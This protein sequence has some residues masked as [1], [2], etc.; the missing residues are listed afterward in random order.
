MTYKGPWIRGI[1]PETYDADKDSRGDLGHA[2]ADAL[3]GSG[4]LANHQ[5]LFPY[6]I[7][8]V[9]PIALKPFG[10][11]PLRRDLLARLDALKQ[12]GYSVQDVTARS[13]SDVVHYLVQVQKEIREQA[14]V[15]CPDILGKIARNSSTTP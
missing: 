13:R 12:E 4:P 11:R 2:L 3:Y 6:D 10:R 5:A 14:R 1:T 15:Y 8:R 9:V 7:T